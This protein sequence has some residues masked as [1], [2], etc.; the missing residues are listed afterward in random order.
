MHGDPKPMKIGALARAALTPVDTIRFYERE[1]LLAA[2][3]RSEGNYRLYGTADV[4]RLAF[5]RQ[6]RNLDMSLDEVRTLLRVKDAPEQ[7]CQAVNELLDA[8]VRHV[9]ERLRE[10]RELERELKSLRARCADVQRSSQACGIL[11]QLDE[12]AQRPSGRRYRGAHG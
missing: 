6:C 12:S 4:Q 10:L 3:P 11:Q 1:G 7:D 9:A 5:I 2:A 8:H